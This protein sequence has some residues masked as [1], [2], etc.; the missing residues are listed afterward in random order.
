MEKQKYRSGS[1]LCFLPPIPDHS[2]L[3]SVPADFIGEAPASVEKLSIFSG[4]ILVGYDFYFWKS[5]MFTSYTMVRA[6]KIS[7][8]KQ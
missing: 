3:K 1:E 6:K 2:E 8:L 4:L 7:S 5:L